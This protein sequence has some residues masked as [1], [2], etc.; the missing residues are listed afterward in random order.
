[1]E[2]PMKGMSLAT[3]AARGHPPRRA[4]E[5]TSAA[6]RTFRGIAV[7]VQGVKYRF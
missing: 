6:P 5:P 4:P 2:D 3:L 7:A 1:M